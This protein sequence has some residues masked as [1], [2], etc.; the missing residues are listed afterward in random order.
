[1]E[2]MKRTFIEKVILIAAWLVLIGGIVC[3]TV[4]SKCILESNL[5]M[6]VPRAF[7]TFVGSIFC[8]IVGWAVLLE[9]IKISD[10]LRQIEKRLSD[11]KG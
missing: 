11:K 9:V 1:M 3:G 10:R 7:C 2:V 6:C 8:S 4:V 5:D